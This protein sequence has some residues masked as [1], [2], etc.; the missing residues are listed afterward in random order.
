M[1]Q[2]TKIDKEVEAF[3]QGAT[4]K[5]YQQLVNLL[6]DAWGQLLDDR[7]MMTG[8]TDTEDEYDILDRQSSLCKAIE[9]ELR[10]WS[11]V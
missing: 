10:K 4:T 11:R 1:T 9:A 3:E 8:N 6:H 7:E 5:E 2:P